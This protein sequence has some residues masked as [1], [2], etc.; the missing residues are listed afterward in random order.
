MNIDLYGGEGLAGGSG[1]VVDAVP[2]QLD[3]CDDLRL[4]RPKFF[5]QAGEDR[6]A[7][8]RRLMIGNRKVVRQVLCGTA[9]KTAKL[10]DPLSFGDGRQPRP[11]GVTRIVGV[12]PPMDRKQRPLTGIV[13]LGI[14]SE[15]RRVGEEGV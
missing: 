15:E 6:S 1:G 5:Y 2:L 13:D 7:G 9:L 11:E 14:S 4:R 10:I 12:T 3:H 8:D